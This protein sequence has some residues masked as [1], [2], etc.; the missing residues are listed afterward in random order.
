MIKKKYTV[1]IRNLAKKQA[2][3]KGKIDEAKASFLLLLFS[4]FYGKRLVD[5]KVYYSTEGCA[6]V[7]FLHLFNSFATV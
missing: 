5:L 3:K 4:L 2:W 1:K 7:F 6:F